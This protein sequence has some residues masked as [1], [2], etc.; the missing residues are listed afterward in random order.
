MP[1]ERAFATTPP[2]AQ[3][4]LKR[5]FDAS[6]PAAWVA[7][8]SVYGENRQLRMWLEESAHAHVLAV[9]GKASVWLAGR[10]QQVKAIL[11]TLAAEGW[12]RLRAGDGAK[13]PRW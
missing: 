3:Q 5:A 7:G 13:G 10:H 6:V 4:M 9:S 12:C 11:A 1:E 2:L 8:E